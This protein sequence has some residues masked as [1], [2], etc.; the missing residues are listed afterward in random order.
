MMK[1]SRDVEIKAVGFVAGLVVVI[2]IFC[3]W[4]ASAVMKDEG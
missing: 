2:A 1:V 3:V 4:L